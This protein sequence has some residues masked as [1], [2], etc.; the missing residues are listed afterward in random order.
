MAEHKGLPMETFATQAKFRAWL[1]KHHRAEGLWV[2]FAKKH[3][4]VKTTTYV[5]AREE[6]I[7]W[8]WIDGLKNGYDET[9]YLLRF[10]PRRARSK[11]SL[12]NRE[13][14]EDLINRGAM[15]PPGLAQVEAARA[16]GRWDRAYPSASRMPVHPALRDA[17]ATSPA[18]RTNFD[19]LDAANRYAVLF[20]VWDAATDSTR[21]RRVQ[22][23]MDMLARGE[24]PHTRPQV[25]T[26]RPSKKTDAA[27]ASASA[28]KKASARKAASE[29]TV[30]KTKTS[31]P[32]ASKTKTSRT[33]ASKKTARTAASKRTASKK[34]T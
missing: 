22:K 15:R 18:A 6:A 3:A 32:A 7:A 23:Y 4:G 33:A 26:R 1:R 8:G 25:A 20:G 19:A 27:S 2:M 24:A 11:W 10:T 21:D 13:I 28:S 14:A 9:Y 29:K 31:R 12:I 34:A 16:D 17:L 30:S 5:E